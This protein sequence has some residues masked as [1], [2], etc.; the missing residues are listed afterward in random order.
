MFWHLISQTDVLRNRAGS[1]LST[2]RKYV[3]RL[4][5]A[6]IIHKI[7]ETNSSF[8][9]KQRTPGKVQFLFFRRF[10]LVLTK[11]SFWGRTKHR[12]LVR[13][14]IYTSLLQIITFRFTC[15][16]R[17]ICSTIKKSQNIMNL[18]VVQFARMKL[19]TIPAV[20]WDDREVTLRRKNFET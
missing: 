1:V 20:N 6:T 10:L 9:V 17:K 19:L 13:Q 12:Q 15:G 18:I 2:G 8:H 11:F 7:F 3:V 16:E 14:L 5:E 4:L